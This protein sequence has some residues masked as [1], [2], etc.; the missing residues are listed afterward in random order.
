ML[1][2]LYI[3]IIAT[4]MYKV[5]PYMPLTLFNWFVPV[6][7]LLY[8]YLLSSFCHFQVFLFLFSTSCIM[9][10]IIILF[11]FLS[12]HCFFLYPLAIPCLCFFIPCPWIAPTSSLFYSVSLFSFRFYPA[13]R[14]LVDTNL[15]VTNGVFGVEIYVPTEFGFSSTNHV[16]AECG[17]E[18]NR[19]LRTAQERYLFAH[20]NNKTP[21]C[22]G[23]NTHRLSDSVCRYAPANKTNPP[24]TCG[25]PAP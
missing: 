16:Y 19:V 23:R 13:F 12:F 18:R 14:V 17:C 9:L 11:N 24:F 10:V 22:T 5:L 20:K 25:A 3:I 6:L 4:I 8:L 15:C 2:R 21:Q 7:F 1:R